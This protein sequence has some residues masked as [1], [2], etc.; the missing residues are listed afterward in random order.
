MNIREALLQEHTR[1]QADKIIDYIGDNQQRFDELITI[2][3]NDE[4]R[5]VQ[6][7]AW[8]LSD[9]VIQ[10]PKLVK[11]HLKRLVDNLAQP[12]IHDAV[13]RNTLRFL[14]E[15]EIPGSLQGRVMNTCFQ[16]VSDPNVPVAIKAFSLTV[17]YNLSQKYPDIQPELK[18]L[19]ETQIPHE[20]AAFR[21][22]AVKILKVLERKAGAK[23]TSKPKA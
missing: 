20:T 2:F 6:R 13:N 15:I 1:Q 21:S 8:P 16:Y 9:I 17:L 14:Q 11:K 12:G 19:I 4:Y 10:H 18:L 23:K 5:V 7:A 3:L 22:R